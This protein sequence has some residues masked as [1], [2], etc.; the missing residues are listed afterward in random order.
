MNERDSMSAGLD[1]RCPFCA[2]DAARVAFAEGEVVALWDL[3]PVNPGHLLLVTRRHVGSWFDATEEERQQL[4]ALT[5]RGRNQIRQRLAEQ[6]LPEPSG[7]NVGVNIGADAGQTVDHLHVH[8][9]P[10]FEGDTPDPVGGV[11][12]VVPARGNY[13]RS[14]AE[15]RI[16]GQAP[17]QRPLVTGAEADPLLPHLKSHLAR[18][19]NFAAAV[20]FVL[21][22]GIEALRAELTYMLENQGRFRILAG[23]YLGATDPDALQHILDFAEAF[24]NQVE[25]RVYEAS[26]RSYHPKFYLIE[27]EDDLGVAFVGSSNLSQMALTAGVEWNYRILSTQHP[28]SF[29]EGKAAFEALFRDAATQPLTSEWVDAYRARRMDLQPIGPPRADGAPATGP[30]PGGASLIGEPRTEPPEAEPPDESGEILEPPTP[31][32]VQKE[33]LRELA[34]TREEGNGAGLVVLATGL[35]KTWLAAFDVDRFAGRALFVAH[36]EEIL[37]Q[38]HTTFRRV[39]PREKLGYFNAESKDLD[40][41]VLFASIQTLSR[42]E[43]LERFAPDHFAHITID[44][45]HHAA[46]D[47]YRRVIEYFR[48]KFLLGLT[49]TPER[50]DGGDLLA[51]CGENLVFRADL[52]EGIQQGDLVPFDYL[53]VPDDVEYQNIPWRSGR[54]DKG[55]LTRA[56]ATTERARN[57]LD[58]LRRHGG[59]RVMA[60][61]ASITHADFMAKW[62]SDHGLRAISVHTGPDSS[63]RVEAVERLRQGDVQ[64]L[65]TVDMF[66][67]GVDI[68]NVDTV[69]MLRPTESKILWLQQIGRGLRKAAGKARLRIIDYVGNHRTFLQSLQVLFGVEGGATELRRMIAELKKQEGRAELPAGCRV[70]YELE[71]LDLLEHL[72]RRTRSKKF[73]RL[74]EWIDDFT[75]AHDHRPSA[76]EAWNEGFDPVGDAKRQGGWFQVLEDCGVLDDDEAASARAHRQFLDV[77]AETKMTR[78]YKMVLLKGWLES[79]RFPDPISLDDLVEAFRAVAHRSGAVALDVSVDLADAAAVRRLLVENPIRYLENLGVTLTDD[80]VHLNPSTPGLSG[81]PGGETKFFSTLVREL[82]EWRLAKYLHSQ[83]RDRRD[84]IRTDEGEWLDARFSVERVH[85]TEYAIIVE[86]RGGA[87]GSK[88]ERNTDYSQGLLVLL[89]RLRA[90]NATLVR[91]ELAART[92]D[93]Q[94]LD[95]NPFTVPLDLQDLPD[96]TSLRKTIQRAQGNNPTRRIRALVTMSAGTTIKTLQSNLA[97]GTDSSIRSL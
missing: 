2:I 12:W 50:T 42:P 66:N 64:V 71:A 21:P 78:S 51:L 75:Q 86:S 38:A 39:M 80:H 4:A 18:A 74:L 40:A 15:A 63:P 6:G 44:E 96:V 32:P 9:I 70:T 92:S 22:K 17:H 16:F 36:R 85:D 35:G 65:C 33:A 45:F 54:F 87:R 76:L 31:R 59:S 1:Q 41:R 26:S 23:D 14:G 7:F 58:Q 57:A 34:L 60:F 72:A 13:R 61:C 27:L 48:P 93:G 69:L 5:V 95:L 62:F 91:V 89:N 10:R 29:Q 82:V 43:N 8:V 47:T 37:R 88:A 77:L 19:K 52:H 68:P 67:E 30:G 11:R 24:P 90:M 56:L 3:Y 79:G 46:A 73:D 28:T 55:E 81:P 53:G 97:H 25:A 94:E 20:A 84:Q 49:A 83:R